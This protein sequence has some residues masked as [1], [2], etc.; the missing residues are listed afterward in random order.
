MRLKDKIALMS[1]V[2]PRMGRSTAY[3]FAQEGA[4]SVI[5]ARREDHLQETVMTIRSKNGDAFGAVGDV[6]KKEDAKRVVQETLDQL[7]RIDILYSG[8]GGFYEPGREFSDVDDA[9]WEKAIDNNLNGLFNLTKAVTPIMKSQGGGTILVI[10]ASFSVRQNGNPAYATAK[11]GLIGFA[12]SLSK[13]LYPDNIRVNV[14]A[15][16]LIRGTEPQMPVIPGPDSL[17]RV[18]L[19]QDIAYASAY[20]VSDEASWVNGQVLAV[21]GGV[22]VNAR[23][24]ENV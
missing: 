17:N 16:G 18:G 22:D 5:V 14:V 1:G 23:S 3:L 2:G 13:E 12:Q 15:P 11:S 9:F 6:A 8:G 24:L 20:L 4:K 21:D 19:V 7:G 10:S